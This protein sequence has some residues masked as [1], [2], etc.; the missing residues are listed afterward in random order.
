MMEARFPL[1][2]GA[3]AL[4]LLVLSLVL[5]LFFRIRNEE[6]RLEVLVQ[7]RTAEIEQQRKLLEYMS[8]TYPLT[9]LPNRRNFDMRLDIEWQIAIREKQKISFLMLDIDYFKNYNDLYGHQQGDEVLCIIAKIIAQA[10]KRP[11]DFVARWGG[12]EFAV[13]LSNTGTS[14]AVKIAEN[15]RTNVENT[16]MP[17]VDGSVAKL[18]I[19]IG[20]NTQ[21]PEQ[22]SSLES[23]ISIADKELYRAKE[24]GR[25]KVCVH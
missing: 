11:G 18:T 16:N 1:L 3:T 8:L 20:V 9:G 2:I 12:E 13:L 17:L 10:P 14:G 21:I 23:F 22:G 5:V 6:K 25:N 15:I 24:M 7:K 19:S 4:S